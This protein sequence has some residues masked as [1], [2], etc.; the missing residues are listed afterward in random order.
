MRSSVDEMSGFDALHHAGLQSGIYIPVCLMLA[1]T[2]SSHIGAIFMGPDNGCHG[3]EVME[4][5]SRSSR[6]A[7]EAVC[8]QEVES[9]RSLYRQRFRSLAT[10]RLAAS[11]CVNGGIPVHC[12]VQEVSFK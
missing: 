9:L 1:Q 4:Q 12:Q 11:I 3:D 2:R 6:Q 7:A 8:N 5:A 10:I